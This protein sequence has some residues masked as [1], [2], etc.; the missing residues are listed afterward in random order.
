MDQHTIEA[1]K[2]GADGF[3]LAVA[4]GM[5]FG[6]VPVLVG[7]ATFVYTMIRIYETKTVQDLIQRIKNRG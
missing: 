1:L 6:L 2:H 3:S 7:V 4:V 5:V